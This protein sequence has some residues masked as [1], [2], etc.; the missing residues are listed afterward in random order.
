MK[1]LILLISALTFHSALSQSDF[2]KDVITWQEELDASYADRAKSPLGKKDFKK[3]K[4]L[5]FY[6]PNENFRVEASVQKTPDAEPFQMRTTTARLATYVK[7]CDVTFELNGETY[8]LE[9]YQS[10]DISKMVEYKD[11]LFLPFLDETN[12]EETY[13]GGRYVDLRLQEG[14]TMIIDFN[15][16][17]NPYCAY[18]SNYSCPIV[19]RVNRLMTKIE[20]G[21]KAF[22]EH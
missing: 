8:S 16:S 7:Y 14:D 10:P 19:P 17:Y 13:G 6:A 3:F 18:S 20:A 1:A 11:Y 2:Q 4:G 21:V 15:K 22:G 9:V 5:D 12:G